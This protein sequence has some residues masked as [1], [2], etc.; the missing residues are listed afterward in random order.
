MKVKVDIETKVFIR[1]VLVCLGFGLAILVIYKTRSAL[2]LLGLSLFLALAL[3][4][5]VSKIA[6]QLPSNS[7]VGATAIAYLVVL[8]VLGG[9][10]VLIVPPVIEQ[11]AKFADTVP[12]LIDEANEQRYIFDDFI[13]RYGLEETVNNAVEGA[14]DQASSVAANLGN[15]LVGGV[16]SLLS[17]VANLII[18]LVLTFLML[19]EGP[20]WMRRLWG[21]YSDTGKLER[22]RDLVKRMYR[23]VTGFVNGQLAVAAIAGVSTLIVLLALSATLGLSANLAVP[24]AVVI[25]FCGMVPM[26]GATIGAVLVGLVLLLNNP[27]AALIFL[28]YFIVYQ[29]I[30]NNFISPTIQSKSVELSALGILAAI[31][32]GVSLGGLLGGVIAIPVAG[33]LRVLLIDQLEHARKKR[34]KDEQ[35]PVKK[36]IKKT[37]PA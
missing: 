19:I 11:S 10:L 16:G 36:L 8:A 13:Q 32:I 12:S 1:F 33:C 3:N 7:R 27:T 30:E 31:L 14:K 22:H 4:P 2:T 28:I 26:V 15:S 9:F 21:L 20:V 6:K 17:G 18:L 5:P 37:K 23:V 35:H 24:L 29:Q 34:A 25:F